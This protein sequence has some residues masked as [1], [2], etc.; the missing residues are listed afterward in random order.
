[1]AGLARGFF[2]F[3]DISGH[4]SRHH[5]RRLLNDLIPNNETH[6]KHSW[7]GRKPSF[8][9]RFAMAASPLY[10]VQRRNLKMSDFT[11]LL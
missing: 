4:M 6:T 2:L 11:T 5:K 10:I 1:M 7:I 3:L 8:Y 9:F